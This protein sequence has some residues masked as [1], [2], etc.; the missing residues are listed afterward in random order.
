MTIITLA[1]NNEIDP[2]VAPAITPAK[3]YM[4]NYNE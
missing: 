4:L 3:M 1:E 2:T